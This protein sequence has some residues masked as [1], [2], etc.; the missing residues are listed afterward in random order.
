MAE[1]PIPNPDSTLLDNEFIFN[2]GLNNGQ[3]KLNEFIGEEGQKDSYGFGIADI[4]SQV[5]AHMRQKF[6][7]HI[8]VWDT[9]VGGRQGVG[10]EQSRKD[11]KGRGKELVH[12]TA[13]INFL[14]ADKIED[15]LAILRDTG[16]HQNYRQWNDADI[17][18][19][20]TQVQ[21]TIP[22]DSTPAAKA[23]GDQ[24]EATHKDIANEQNANVRPIKTTGNVPGSQQGGY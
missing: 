7:T 11:W 19:F 23:L 13:F 12:D 24:L 16:L 18:K 21:G 6:Q 9:L 17:L 2:E 1:R 14:D 22:V 5:Q 10:Y 15:K 8:S 20:I 4:D 3:P